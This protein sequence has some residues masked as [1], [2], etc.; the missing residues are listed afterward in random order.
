MRSRCQATRTVCGA[1]GPNSSGRPRVCSRVCEPRQEAAPR[2]LAV[3]PTGNGVTSTQDGLKRA[4]VLPTRRG[5]M[6]TARC[7]RVEV[8][9]AAAGLPWVINRGCALRRWEGLVRFVASLCGPAR[10]QRPAVCR[11]VEQR[12]VVGSKEMERHALRQD[13]L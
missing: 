1:Y 12:R 8:R 13:L 4:N 9:P 11:N 2:S 6:C 3:F 10:R 7:S 5:W